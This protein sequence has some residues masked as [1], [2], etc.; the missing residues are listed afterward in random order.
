MFSHYKM[1]YS[2]KTFY[3]NKTLKMNK[4]FN[5]GQPNY[6]CISNNLL[7]IEDNNEAF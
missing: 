6:M 4:F 7:T 1:S 3:K 2:Y 5:T